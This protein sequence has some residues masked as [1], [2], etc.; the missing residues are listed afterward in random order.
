MDDI[1]LMAV[2]LLSLLL[3][4]AVCLA[5]VYRQKLRKQISRRSEE[6]ESLTNENARLI[7]EEQK[8]RAT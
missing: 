3:L 2:A 7:A 4:A 5:F 6:L 8:K 1:S